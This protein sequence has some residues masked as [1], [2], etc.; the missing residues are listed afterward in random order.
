M[1]LVPSNAAAVLSRSTSTEVQSRARE[2]LRQE[3]EVYPY[4]LLNIYMNNPFLRLPQEDVDAMRKVARPTALGDLVALRDEATRSRAPKCSVFCMPKSGSSFIQSALQNS[5]QL[6]LVSLTSFATPVGSSAFGMNGREQEVDELALIKAVLVNPAG[7][8][9]QHHTRFTPFLGLQMQLYRIQPVVTVRNILDCIVSF[10]DMMRRW[11][12]NAGEKH[13]P[14]D[15]QFALP[16]DFERRPQDERYTVL[17]HSLGIWLVNFYVSWRRGIREGCVSPLVIRYED[18]VLAPDRLAD[19][20][21][22]HFQ[23]DAAQQ[24]R[25]AAYVE[26]PDPDSARLNVGR[27]GRGE[28]LI[29]ERLKVFLADY[30][31]LFSNELTAE[32][33]RYLVR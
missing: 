24:A 8:V 10:D 16:L 19:L 13:W 28:D 7:F 17:A 9:A 18:D 33:I 2:I 26:R 11:R 23:L 6:P 14:Y 32:E 1:N 12:G 25:L 3:G 27:K 31:G 20:L 30:V 21:T 5:L 29:P 4:R 22:R 15:P